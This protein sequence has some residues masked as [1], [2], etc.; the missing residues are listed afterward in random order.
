MPPSSSSPKDYDDLI[1]ALLI[2]LIALLFTFGIWKQTP[3]KNA[4][5]MDH[6]PELEITEASTPAPNLILKETT[7][8]PMAQEK[9]VKNSQTKPIDELKTTGIPEDEALD[10]VNAHIEHSPDYTKLFTLNS[11]CRSQ[12]CIPMSLNFKPGAK[13]KQADSEL[14]DHDDI[15]I[16][17][18][19]SQG[20]L[21]KTHVMIKKDALRCSNLQHL[22]VIGFDKKARPIVE[23][24]KGPLTLYDPI[25]R[26]GQKNGFKLY[27]GQKKLRN[28]LSPA[29]S[30]TQGAL[31]PENFHI[32][33]SGK[34]FFKKQSACIS[35]TNSGLFKSVALSNCS[36][37]LELDVNYT[38]TLS[39]EK[40]HKQYFP[41][42]NDSQY[43]LKIYQKNCH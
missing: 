8:A 7:P 38:N 6:T 41:S 21:K 36:H 14:E 20:K 37:P 34:I 11:Q 4:V 25:L 42:N 2:L 5:K 19:H 22:A 9:S 31:R 12:A 23:T 30:M 15:Q 40:N 13:F 28:L 3:A 27:R 18:R 43:R 33:A 35:Y 10:I 39:N 1:I 17:A 32:N 16:L 24:D 29:Q 26:V